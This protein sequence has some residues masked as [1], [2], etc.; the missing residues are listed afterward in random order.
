MAI[1]CRLGNYDSERDNFGKKIFFHSKTSKRIRFWIIF[2]NTCQNL[3][4]KFYKASS[5]GTKIIFGSLK[6]VFKNS[7]SSVNLHHKNVENGITVFFLDSQNLGRKVRKRSNNWSKFFEKFQILN[8]LFCNA[9]D[10]DKKF[11]NVS[12]FEPFFQKS[13]KLELKN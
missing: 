4:W 7:V 1:S 8:Q 9:W 11:L 2:F 13:S 6:S 5:F 10:F 3:I 12:V